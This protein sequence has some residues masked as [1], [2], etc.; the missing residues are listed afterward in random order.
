MVS[1][2]PIWLY[3]GVC[4]LCSTAVRYVLAHEREPLIRFVA[5]QSGEGQRLSQQHGLDLQS[6]ETFLFLE[7]DRILKKSDAA[8][9][10]LKHIKGPARALGVA[11]FIPKAW[12]DAAYDLIARHRYKIFGR[13]EACHLPSKETLHRFAL[14]ENV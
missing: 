3:D 5:I 14:P 8:I 10:L 4:V 12:R 9:A 11:G 2:Q 6:P 13:Y 7:E 1:N